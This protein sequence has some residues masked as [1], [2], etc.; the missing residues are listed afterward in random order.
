[1]TT[2]EALVLPPTDAIEATATNSICSVLSQEFLIVQH[3]RCVAASTKTTEQLM[4]PPVK[5]TVVASS[6][7]TTIGN[8]QDINIPYVHKKEIDL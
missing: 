7:I 4:V 1:M 5:I 6:P 3:I 8:Q 2:P